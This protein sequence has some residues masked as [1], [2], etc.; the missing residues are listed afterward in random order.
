MQTLPLS[1]RSLIKRI[2]QRIQHQPIAPFSFN[3]NGDLRKISAV[4]FL[5]GQDDNH[6]P[7]LILNKRSALVRQPGDLCCPGGGVSLPF[8]SL[9]ARWLRLPKMPLAI[10]KHGKWWRQNRR[11]DFRKLSLLLATALREGVEEMRLNPFGVLFLGPMP[12][13]SLVMF[14][15]VI[16][17]LVAW[18]NRQQ[19]FVP[20]WEVESIVR[21]PL[22]SFFDP[23]N[24]ARYR[25]SF[26]ADDTA[27]TALSD[28]DL[29]CFVHHHNGQDELLWGATHR[30]T[31]RFLATVFDF[32]PPPMESLP[33]I[34]GRLGRQY[35]NGAKQSASGG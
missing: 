21:I 8:D 7:M 29:G 17:P 12:V 13:Q 31:L 33:L 25:V 4:L 20:N 18:V 32:A 14:N 35:L 9:M 1:T 2:Q 23:S 28:R 11:T 6:T 15:R 27:D 26:A 5:L 19:H 16:Y 24:Y 10:W 3:I 30:I 34:H 22:A